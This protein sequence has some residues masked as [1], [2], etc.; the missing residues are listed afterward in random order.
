MRRAAAL[1]CLALAAQ[2][3]TFRTTVPEVQAPVTVTGPKGVYAPG[4]AAGDFRLLDNGQEQAIRL[5]SADELMT[6]IAMVVA[7]QLNDIAQPALLKIRRTG[8]LIE[9]L[10][11]GTRGHAAVLTYSGSVRKI[12]D[13]TGQGQDLIDCFRTLRPEDYR[14]AHLLDALDAGLDELRRRPRGERRILLF[15]GESRDRGSATKLEELLPRLQREDITVYAAA[16]SAYKTAFTVKGT[17]YR[18]PQGGADYL[19]AISETIRLAKAHHADVL[20]AQTGG[21]KFSF[22]TLHGLETL[23]TTLGE[24]LHSQYLLS[25]SPTTSTPGFHTIEVQLRR[26]AKLKVQTRPGYWVEAAP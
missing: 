12:Q 14:D 17:E 24:E 7:V 18:P 20:A 3:P 13:F 23:L 9:P 10:I 5:L 15:I 16:Y 4:L 8:S 21:R 11:T 25:Y 22:A 2:P 19:G 26:H 6:P 1:V